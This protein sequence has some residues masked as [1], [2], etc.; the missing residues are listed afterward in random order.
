VQEFFVRQR[1]GR[2][3]INKLSAREVEAFTILERELA[4]EIQHVQQNTRTAF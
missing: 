4:A 3:D 2:W 1:L